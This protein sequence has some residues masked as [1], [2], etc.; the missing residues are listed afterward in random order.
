MS[1]AIVQWN[2]GRRTYEDEVDEQSENGSLC[3]CRCSR[4]QESHDDEH[5][6][7][8]SHKLSAT[9]HR[10]AGKE[11]TCPAEPI[12]KSFLRPVVSI[13]GYDPKAAKA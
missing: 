12:K 2:E 5:S 13:N 11:R 3:E 1:S 4:D 9:F 7:R 10:E 6:N 8:L